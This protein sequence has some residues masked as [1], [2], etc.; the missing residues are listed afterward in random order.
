MNIR[1]GEDK[2]I[3]VLVK[4]ENDNLIDLTNVNITQIRCFLW[5]GNKQVEKY[6]LNL[7]DPNYTGYLPLVRN[8]ASRFDI[9]LFRNL[10]TQIP[11][12]TLRAVVVITNTD[13]QFPLGRNDKY[14]IKNL[15]DV[16]PEQSIPLN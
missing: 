11:V 2:I 3:T 7:P 9:K 10:T 1:Q 8:G 5:V 6:A 4:D 16:L 14:E 15:A 12:G 13:T